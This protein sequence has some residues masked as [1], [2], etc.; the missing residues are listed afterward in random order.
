MRCLPALSRD[1]A[2][3]GFA[4]ACQWQSAVAGPSMLLGQQRF[5]C[6]EDQA[7]ELK[8]TDNAVRRASQEYSS[9]VAPSRRRSASEEQIKAQ[10]RTVTNA[11]IS[12]VRL[13]ICAV[14]VFV[15]PSRC[16]VFRE[17]VLSRCDVSHLLS[18]GHL[19]ALCG[20]CER[21]PACHNSKSL[22][23][24]GPFSSNVLVSRSVPRPFWSFCCGPY[25]SSTSLFLSKI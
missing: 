15:F 19:K 24:S 9:V 22:I 18:C 8:S 16:P 13:C 2:S 11:G 10:C 6:D 14:T 7:S 4:G 20:L 3:E 21:F 5:T 17:S 1:L 23:R 12:L 25:T